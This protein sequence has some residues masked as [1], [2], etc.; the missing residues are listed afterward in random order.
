MRLFPDTN[1]NSSSTLDA[2]TKPEILS[3]Q[4]YGKVGNVV[5]TVRIC[6]KRR[7][8]V[9]RD[10]ALRLAGVDLQAPLR[11]ARARGALD[12][13]LERALAR[14][15]PGTPKSRARVDGWR[16]A[17]LSSSSGLIR[18]CLLFS[19]NCFFCCWL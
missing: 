17:C 9:H 2:R 7:G 18:F 8:P 6:E 15:A 5:G 13:V 16:V 1:Q 11:V 10:D 12:R 3:L 4:R 19:Q 14:A